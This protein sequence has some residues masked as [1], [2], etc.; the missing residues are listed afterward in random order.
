MLSPD[1][2]SMRTKS[3]GTY[4]I[5]ADIERLPEGGLAL[6]NQYGGAGRLMRDCESAAFCVGATAKAR[7]QRL[8]VPERHRVPVDKKP[9]QAL[10]TGK[11]GPESALHAVVR[12]R[13]QLVHQQEVVVV[14]LLASRFVPLFF[15]SC[16][17][18]SS[19][20]PG[21]SETLFTYS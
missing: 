6:R 1:P 19:G 5:P 10:V 15:N 16:S 9:R 20:L 2:R 21:L 4:P 12:P 8:T 17:M 14:V 13:R 7:M 11:L 3:N 18:T